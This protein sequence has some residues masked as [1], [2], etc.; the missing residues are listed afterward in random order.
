M[1]RIRHILVGVDFDELSEHALDYALDVAERFDA[2]VTVLHAYE[3]PTVGFPDG[4]LLATDDIATRVERAATAGLAAM[5]GKR[6]DRRLRLDGMV[7]AGVAWQVIRDVAEEVG[8]DLVIVG[9][10]GRRGFARA[11][12]GSVAE[13][14]IRATHRPV[15]AVHADAPG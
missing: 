2:A 12:L 6:K 4:A 11:L 9:T 3:I 1:I 14:V 7:R 13:H 5:V 15:L 10:H 8:A